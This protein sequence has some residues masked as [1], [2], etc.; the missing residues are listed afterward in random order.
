MRSAL[1]KCKRSSQHW[2]SLKPNNV[3]GGEQWGE[4]DGFSYSNGCIS[5]GG[6][7]SEELYPRTQKLRLAFTNSRHL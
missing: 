1:L 6:R 7:K 2:I 5:S 4:L 3:L